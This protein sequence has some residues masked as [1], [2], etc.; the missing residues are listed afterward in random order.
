M[1][2]W[3]LDLT[4]P[5]LFLDM[6]VLPLGCQSALI[7]DL[8]S[9][10]N[11]SIERALHIRNPTAQFRDEFTGDQWESNSEAAVKK[12]C[13]NQKMGKTFQSTQ[14][15]VRYGRVDKTRNHRNSSYITAIN[16]FS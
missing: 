3:G 13:L 14:Q 16:F 11:I 10:P 12:C 1:S 2:L 15:I 4:E 9:H 6:K 8:N 7:S 5:Q